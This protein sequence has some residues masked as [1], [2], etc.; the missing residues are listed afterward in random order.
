MKYVRDAQEFMV[1]EGLDGWLTYDY[2]HSSTVFAALA[3]QVG[4]LTRPCFLFLPAAG[5]PRLLVHS[6]DAGK[7][8]GL[9]AEK[10]TYSSRQEL[11]EALGRLLGQGQKVAMEYSPDAELPRVSQVDGGTLE[12][13]R[14]LGG[15]VVSSA[16]LL[17][18]A[19]QR[20]T[21]LQLRL[22]R[23]VARKLVGLVREAFAHVSAGLG[24]V[25]LTELSVQQFL[26]ERFRELGLVSDAGP[27]V[28]VNRHAADPHYEPSP[29]T[30]L[31]IGQGDWLLLDLW[32]KEDNAQAVY[33]DIT[34]VGYV[35]Q[36]VPLRFRRAF[37][38]V[39]GARDAALELLF[40]AHQEGRSIQGWEV[41]RVARRYVEREGLGRNFTHR[42]GHSLGAE[43]HGAAVN[44]D[45][46]ETH[47]TRTIIP[48]IGFTIE[49]GL[50]F[51]S[52]G[53]RSEIDV[54]WSERGPEV[55]T[56]VQKEILLVPR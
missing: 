17:Q 36:K 1:R 22:H 33:A 7:F 34:W 41:D 56:E 23:S 9:R 54:F 31:P 8:H 53:V 39:A 37:E 28:Q 38:V 13:V 47:D 29:A 16:D 55:T 3:G 27:I 10:R 6:V 15:E 5:L 45:D 11:R 2:R 14:S 4:M 24:R 25:E 12:L 50:Y 51:R 26:L 46:W 40:K 30:S 21:S 20:W 35:G 48:G 18:F 44:L 42:L 49:P 19:T 43:V 32:A 52:F